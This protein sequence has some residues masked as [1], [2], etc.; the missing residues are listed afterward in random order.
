MQNRTLVMEFIIR[1]FLGTQNQR[2]LFFVVFLAI[3]LITVMGNLMIIVLTSA[4]SRLSTPMYF[5][6][7]NLSFLDLFCIS[8]TV[9]KM[10][11]SFLEDKG[12]ISFYGCAAQ[13]Y[14][15]LFLACTESV[16]LA[17]MAYDRYVAIC[18]P[19]HYTILM[20]RRVCIQ[21]IAISWVAG[22]ISAATHTVNT[23]RLPYCRSNVINHFFCDIPAL[24]NIACADIYINQVVVLVVG[25]FLM[26]GC[27]FL[28][29]ISYMRIISSVLRIP[30]GQGRGKA[31]S[32]CSSHLI[33]VM[34]FYGT[35]SFTYLKPTSSYSANEDS[36]IS[37]F[38]AIITPMLNPII[39]SLRNKEIQEAMKKMISGKT[40]SCR[41]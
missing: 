14:F 17:S 5:F 32:T 21:M 12:V 1:G 35:G 3:Y 2:V 25:G 15:F 33:V 11:V 20:N 7:G 24:L 39:Y 27:C 26:L 38:Y 41:I 4:D 37:V 6:L 29:I 9:P 34:L 22:N 16:I 23:F 31:F 8:T 13:L 10:L 18:D 19:L 30:S 36:V 28:I 40:F